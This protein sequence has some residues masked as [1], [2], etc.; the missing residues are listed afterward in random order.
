MG[1]V[2]GQL[3]I[4][5]DLEQTARSELELVVAGTKDAVLMVEAGAKEVPE[6]VILEAIE[7]GHREIQ[8]IV[9]LQETNRCRGG[10]A[11]GR[12]PRGY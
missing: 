10:Q 1:K 2:D 5:P 8:R 4:N 9:A 12:S 7:F 3:I 11:Q 6:D